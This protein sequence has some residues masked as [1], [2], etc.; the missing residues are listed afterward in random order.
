MSH[1][2]GR[3]PR[4]I[5]ALAALAAVLVLLGA[6]GRASADGDPASD[7]LTYQ[8]VFL[9]FDPKVSS[10]LQ[11]ELLKLTNEAADQSYPI[12]VAIIGSKIDLG[13]IPQLFGKPQVYA[14]FLYQEISFAYQGQLLIVMPQGLGSVGPV[15]PDI[16]KR[17][18][19]GITVDPNA[20]P[21]GL[22]RA[23]IEAVNRIAVEA[24]HPLG[25]GGGSM[26]TILAAVGA[27]VAIGG[28]IGFALWRRTRRPSAPAP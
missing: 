19:A 27:A 3:R 16:V 6:A 17:A 22:A 15:S 9:P 20:G 23:A 25:G 24:G 12:R 10:G 26:G 4:P 7:Y 14:R 8:K 1:R 5:A 13:A 28:A 11:L 18:L 2:T 21:D